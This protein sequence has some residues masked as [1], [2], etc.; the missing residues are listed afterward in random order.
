[1]ADVLPVPKIGESGFRKA[2]AQ[3]I[4][5]LKGDADALMIAFSEA[6]P[7]DDTRMIEVTI[8]SSVKGKESLVKSG[9]MKED[10]MLERIFPIY[11]EAGRESEISK[12]LKK[13]LRLK[14]EAKRP[15]ALALAKRDFYPSPAG[16]EISA[17]KE[18]IRWDH[19]KE[20]L[21]RGVSEGMVTISFSRRRQTRKPRPPKK[22]LNLKMR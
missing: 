1:M 6:A 22:P 7:E 20:N 10:L 18:I 21:M 13:G 9:L 16:D 14:I 19:M 15:A 12:Y 5:A 8:S 17:A 11:G 2:C 4:K 3:A